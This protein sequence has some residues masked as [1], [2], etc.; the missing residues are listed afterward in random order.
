MF[1]A[2]E[3]REA[4]AME[5]T[6]TTTEATSHTET[7][8]QGRTVR[9]SLPLRRPAG[10]RMLAGVAAGIADYL[11]VDPTIVRIAIVVLTF[12]GGAG[13][14]LYLA[15]WLLI[16]EEGSDQSLASDLIQSV[17]ARSR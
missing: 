6:D 10:D 17:S 11:G 13:I 16:P 14:P 1:S 8:E 12:I 4:G 9:G 2:R 5:T 7:G 15:G 3:G